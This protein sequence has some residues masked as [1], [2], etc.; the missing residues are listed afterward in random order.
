M[1]KADPFWFRSACYLLET[2]QDEIDTDNLDPDQLEP[3]ASTYEEMG[4]S[5]EE[6]ADGRAESWSLLRRI[7]LK[8]IQVLGD[9]YEHGQSTED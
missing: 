2:L 5:W 4:G 7:C 1:S 9:I 8:W 6:L 3:I